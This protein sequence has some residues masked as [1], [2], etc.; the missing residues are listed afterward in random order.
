MNLP[1]FMLVWGG[2]GVVK[3]RWY[4]RLVGFY[5]RTEG[6]HDDGLAINVRR[7]LPLLFALGLALWFARA[8]ALHAVWENNPYSLLTYSDALFFP[9]RQEA[10]HTKRGQALIARG[11]D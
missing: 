1:R 6:A 5:G 7:G 9:L 3:V 2:T 10:I 8:A 11:T 4:F